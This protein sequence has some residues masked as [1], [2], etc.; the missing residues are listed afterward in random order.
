MKLVL[1]GFVIVLLV[2][3]CVIIILLIGWC[4]MVGGVFQVELDQFGVQVFVQIKQK[5]KVSIDG[6]QNFYVQCVVD[7]LVVQ[8]L[9]Q[10]CG[11]WW[12]M[13][14]FVDSEFNV[15][16]LFGGKV[17][18]NLGIFIV[19]KNQDQFVVVIGYEIGYV[20]VCYYEECIICQMGVQIGLSV[21]GMFVGVVYGDVVVSMVNQFGGMIVQIVFLL[22]GLCIQEFEVDVLGQCLMVEVG[23]DLVQ[24]V[25]LW[26][27]MMVVS[28]GCLLQWMFIYFDFSNWIWELQCD[29]FVFVDVYQQVQVVGWCLWC[30]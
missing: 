24:V 5:E 15:F 14:V 9:F 30:G 10:Y 27:N 19:V 16:V 3:V 29:V 20:I 6:W 12:E 2:S 7:V 22:F 8:L 1:L 23:F 17:G 28:S 13:V 11:V 26:Q 18:V 4:Q 25:N 21:F